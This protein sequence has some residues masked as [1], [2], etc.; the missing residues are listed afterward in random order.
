MSSFAQIYDIRTRKLLQHYV[1]HSGPVHD[2][3]FHPSGRYLHSFV[4]YFS[5]NC[6]KVKFVAC[7]CDHLL[8]S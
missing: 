6:P 8:S 3:S 7:L 4:L 5:I 2:L 1:A